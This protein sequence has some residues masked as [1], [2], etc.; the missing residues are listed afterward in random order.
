MMKKGKRQIK[1]LIWKRK[2]S[3][4]VKKLNLILKRSDTIVINWN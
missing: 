3:F 2:R 1:Q 4:I